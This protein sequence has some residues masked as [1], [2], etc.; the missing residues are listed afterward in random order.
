MREKS[1]IKENILQY[2][3]FKNISK[4]EFYQKTGVSNGVL[5]QKSGMSEENTVRFL[6]YYKDVNP[7]WLLTGKG[8]MLKTDNPKAVASVGPGEGIPL[9][10]VDAFGSIGN[11]SGY[12][13]DLDKIEDRYV[14]P[15]FDG[16]GVDFL[17][18]VRG[19]SMYP[20][21]SSGDVVACRFIRELLFIQWNK[22]YVLDSKSQG[23]M[24][25]RLIKSGDPEKVICRSDNK[26]YGDFEVP[27]DDI[28]NIALVVGVIRLE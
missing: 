3:D 20:K 6:S 14:V 12:S 24:I 25:K 13:I 17:I 21:Y 1:I 8:E 15:L 2:L 23:T 7:E 4:Y 18:A 19:S 28:Q 11:N 22:V 27:L 5:S 10:P 16:K 26:E 9:I